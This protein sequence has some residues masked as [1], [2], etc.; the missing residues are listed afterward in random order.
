[1]FYKHIFCCCCCCCFFK[2]YFQ[3]SFICFFRVYASLSTNF[4]Y[5]A[6]IYRGNKGFIVINSGSDGILNANLNTG[7]PAG[8]YCDVISGNYANGSCT[9]S[10]VHVGSD[11][12]AQFN[13]NAHSDD[14]V[15]AIHIGEFL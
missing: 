15:V 13:I 5:P 2:V 14:P 11:G 10:T 4:Q 1:M 6:L 12:H 7:L 3:Y 9:G 8:K